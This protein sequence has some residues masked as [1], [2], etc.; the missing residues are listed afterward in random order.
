MCPVTDSG[1]PRDRMAARDPAQHL[2]RADRQPL[3]ALFSPR[4]VA[5]VEAGD[6]PGSLGYS[7]LQNLI[8]RPFG[9]KVFAVH[10]YSPSVLGIVSYPSVAAIPEPVDLAVITAPAPA[11]PEVI[12]QCVAAGVRAAIVVSAGFRE[13]GEAGRQLEE[14]VRR[15]IEVPGSRLRVVGPNCL[16][17]MN[18]ITG[19]NATWAQ[20]SARPGNIAFLSQSGALCAA[21][22]DWSKREMVGFSGLV[23]LGSMLDVGW[24]DLIDHFGDD[25]HTRSIVCYMESMGDARAFLSAARE[26][27][28]AKPILVI[29]AGRTESAARAAVSHTGVLAGSDEVLEAAFRRCGVL[30]VNS[31]EDLFSMSEVLAKQP[32]PRGNRLAILTNAG[33]PGVLAADALTSSGGKLADLA[34][35]T[36]RS[37]QEVLPAPWSQGNPV[38]IL[39][40]ADGERMSQ[41]LQR[42]I[43]D[44]NSDGL[45][46]IVAPLG[47][48][49]PTAFAEL[50]K[51]YAKSTGKP[52]LACFMGGTEMTGANEILNRAGIPTFSFPDVAAHA[53]TYMWR[54]TYNL[55]GLY[56]TPALGEAA[57]PDR[58]AA[59]GLIAGVRAS[60]RSLLSADESRQL[61]AAYRIPMADTR[62]AKTEEEALDAAT[63]LGFPVALKLH[64]DLVVHKTDVGGLRLSI[65][66]AAGLRQAFR[67]IRDNAVRNLGAEHFLGVA[68]QPM[69]AP[70]SGNGY[71]VILGSRVD[72]QFGPVLLF[73]SGGQWVEVYGDRALALPPLNTTLA[74]RMMEQTRI[75]AA[76]QGRQGRPTV[77]MEALEQLLVRFSQLVIEQPWIREIDINPLLVAP[78]KLIAL[79]ARVILH[80]P[81]VNENNLPRPAIRPYPAQYAEPWQLKDGTPV[82]IRPVRPEDE[83]AMVR[84]HEKLSERSVYLRYF[85]PL[86]LSQRVSHERLLRLCFL[87]YDREMAL[88]VLAR[89]VTGGPEEI[90][91]VGRLSKLHGGNRAECAVLVGDQY[92]RQG[93]GTE[94]FRRL[95]RVARAERIER[96]VATMLAENYEMRAICQRLGFRVRIDM[97]DGLAEAEIQ[98]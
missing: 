7:V 94:L 81:E 65:P 16:G 50:L 90:L 23:S 58:V 33:G 93:L 60:A 92:Q 20:T 56:E 12:S 29:K 63:A 76:M 74:R 2:L 85:Q 39:G 82:L 24:G 52:V 88:V 42:V 22:L 13:S 89:P 41:G 31:L 30:R 14:E 54:Y 34:P 70:E 67:T 17:V 97:E 3:A 73:G 53:F 79:D 80:G 1:G 91:A 59:A 95:L 83:P 36:L 62:L 37:L 57:D 21:I 48:T 27:S 44:P 64:T 38:D 19:L 86:K 87:D 84:F 4:S 98:P 32:R 55:R 68:V 43:K 72:P 71:E 26:V 11:V 61:L 75:H 66:D 45:L 51:P 77:D 15:R 35:E 5:V 18:P 9:G 49:R 25:P 28:L 40:D 6:R 10:R 96:V 47:I 8:S 46:V 78:N 69:I